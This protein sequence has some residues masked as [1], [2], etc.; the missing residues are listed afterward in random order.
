MMNKGQMGLQRQ[1]GSVE[2][3]AEGNER[4]RP[5]RR[6][7]GGR[8]RGRGRGRGGRGRGYGRGGGRGGGRGPIEFNGVDL[9]DPT[10]RL[11]D[12]EM[13]RLG[14]VG[15][16]FLMDQRRYVNGRNGGRGGG[17]GRGG[18]GNERNIGAVDQGGQ[19]NNG[20]ATTDETTS[21]NG[22]ATN[23]SARNGDRFGR[24]GGR[25]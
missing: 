14:P 24:T 7:G 23:G 15:Q 4:G 1:A 17:R 5:F 2:T 9:S 18:R 8:G 6:G 20:E 13:Q 21:G 22:Q 11:T 3:D 10:R 25:E 16:R 19:G 12:D